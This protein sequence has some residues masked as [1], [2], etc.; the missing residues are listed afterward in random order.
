MRAYLW[1]YKILLFSLPNTFTC[2]SKELDRDQ[3]SELL[4]IIRQRGTS[5]FDKFV[6]VLLESETQASLG[7]LL[8]EGSWQWKVDDDKY[9]IFPTLNSMIVRCTMNHY[10]ST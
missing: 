9:G 3:A 1:R 7:R 10:L 2:R 6:K 5:A 8:K 4:K